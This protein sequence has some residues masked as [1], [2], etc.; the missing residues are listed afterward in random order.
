[1]LLQQ[2][3]IIT[4]GYSIGI[5]PDWLIESELRFCEENCSAKK[6]AHLTFLIL[7]Q[8]IFSFAAVAQWIEYWPPKPRV[9]GSI[10]ASRTN[11][12]SQSKLAVASMP[13]YSCKCRCKHIK[14]SA[15]LANDLTQISF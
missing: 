13:R 15:A 9:V 1:M 2:P 10:P 5:A 8:I 7:E 11:E 4:A 6:C 14:T 12:K 3:A